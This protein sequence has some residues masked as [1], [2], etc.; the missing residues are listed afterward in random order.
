MFAIPGLAYRYTGR[1]TA[2]QNSG[3]AAAHSRLWFDSV[4]IPQGIAMP[5]ALYFTTVVF[6][7]FLSPFLMPISEVT[8]RISTK[9][10]HILTYD[11]YLKQLFRTPPHIYP[12]PWAGDKPQIFGADFEL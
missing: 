1:S 8:E 2:S 4:I 11:F 6:S 10:G 3:I 9:L 5:K 12:L 7:F